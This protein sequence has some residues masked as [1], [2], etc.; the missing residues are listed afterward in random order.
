MNQELADHRNV[1]PAVAPWHQLKSTIHLI[2]EVAG[3]LSQPSA[4]GTT[5]ARTTA[6]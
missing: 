3:R 5:A 2:L 1:I 4:R 6:L